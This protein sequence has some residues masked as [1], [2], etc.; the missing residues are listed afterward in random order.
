MIALVVLLIFESRE[1][2]C[3]F[4]VDDLVIY[5]WSFTTVCLLMGI[6]CF[7]GEVF[8]GIHVSSDSNDAEIIMQCLGKCCACKSHE[9]TKECSSSGERL[10]SVPELLST[11][12]GP[13]ALIYW[14]VTSSGKFLHVMTLCDTI[15]YIYEACSEG[16]FYC[17]FMC[18][19]VQRPFGLGKMHLEGGACLF[20]GQ[21]RGTLGCYYLLYRQIHPFSAVVVSMLPCYLDPYPSF[22]FTISFEI[23]REEKLRN[24]QNLVLS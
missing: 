10:N 19:K 1:F 20:T 2:F 18:R 3:T 5:F 6:V 4:Y 16:I 21:V 12:K 11:I 13:W 7:I 8:G 23:F 17:F 15:F 9:H 14:Q 22:F 24:K